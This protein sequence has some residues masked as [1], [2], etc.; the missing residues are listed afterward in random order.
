MTLV[1]LVLGITINYG[2]NFKPI[3][4]FDENIYDYVIRL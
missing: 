1:F 2:V 3:K 4:S